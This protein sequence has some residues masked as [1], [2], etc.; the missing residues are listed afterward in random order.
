MFMGLFLWIYKHKRLDLIEQIVSYGMNNR[1]WLGLW[2]MGEG[3]I[4]RTAIRSNLQGT[5]HELMF[6]LGGMDSKKRKNLQL[7]S[8]TTGYQAHLQAL[9]VFLRTMLYGKMTKVQKAAMASLARK[10]PNNALFQAVIGN[11]DAAARVLLNER[12]F[13]ADRLPTS[14]DRCSFYLFERDERETKRLTPVDG[15][16]EYMGLTGVKIEECGIEQPTHRVVMRDDWLP[17]DD[18]KIHSGVDFLFTSAI[19][20]GKIRA[21][22]RRDENIYGVMAA[23]EPVDEY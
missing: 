2:I 21:H 19:L 13:P 18:G 14:A 20:L 3:D 4:M 12:F 23:P 7:W 17:C 15:C 6:Q 11:K 1:D 8:T 9:H 16:I 5:I 22:E 10:Q